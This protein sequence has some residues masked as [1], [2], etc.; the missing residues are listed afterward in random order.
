M[1][2]TVHGRLVLHNAIVF[3]HGALL[4]LKKGFSPSRQNEH[5]CP[6]LFYFRMDKLFT[7]LK[8]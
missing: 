8:V 6:V 2:E 3:M 4:R 5:L 1:L 7:R